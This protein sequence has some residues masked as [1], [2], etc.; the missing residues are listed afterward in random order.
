MQEQP[1][2]GGA[3]NAVTRRGNIVYRTGGPW[4]P[5]IHAVLDYLDARGFPY[6]PKALGVDEQG[7]ELISYLPGSSMMRP[8]QP[9][10]FTDQALVQAT[11]MLRELHAATLDLVLPPETDWRSGPAAK[12]AGQVIRHGDLGPWNTL[13]QGDRLTGLIDWDFA[14]PGMAITDLVQLALYFVPLRGEE[15][16]RACG[17]PGPPDFRHRLAVIC[18][19]YGGIEP[20]EVVAEIVRLQETAMEEITTRAAEGRYPWTMFLENGEVARTQAEVAWLHS[21]LPEWCAAP[22]PALAHD[23]P[24]PS[25]GIDDMR[26]DRPEPGCIRE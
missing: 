6:A 16:W 11:R 7:R 1:L 18:D 20:H 14:E 5:A 13:W 22:V 2:T 8:W 17:F 25:R 23:H 9:V 21:T 3:I 26:K 15:H 4:V 24:S 12:P 10:M 19:T